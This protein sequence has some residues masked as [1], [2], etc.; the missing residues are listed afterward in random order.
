MTGLYTFLSTVY[1]HLRQPTLFIRILRVCASP[2]W[3]NIAWMFTLARQKDMQLINFSDNAT[4]AQMGKGWFSRIFLK[5]FQVFHGCM[6]PALKISLF[7]LDKCYEM[8]YLSGN[9]LHCNFLQVCD[10][11][12]ILDCLLQLVIS[13]WFFKHLDQWLII[14]RA[15]TFIWKEKYS[16]SN[17]KLQLWYAKWFHVMLC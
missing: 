7:V 1:V 11:Q 16:M 17:V 4:L 3:Y 15:V 8:T 5:L 14:I 12:E 2:E 6:N 9:L 13:W 10:F